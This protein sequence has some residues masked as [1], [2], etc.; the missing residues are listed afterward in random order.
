MSAILLLLAMAWVAL[1]GGLNQLPR[2][3]TIGQRVETAVQL[4]CGLLSLLSA[5]TCFYWHR[6]RRPIRAAWAISLTTAAGMSSVVW[7]PP[8]LTVGLALAVGALLVALTIIWLLQVG[9]SS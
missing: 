6:L 5:V 3:R 2:S 8:M 1:S 7:G 4:A 9:G